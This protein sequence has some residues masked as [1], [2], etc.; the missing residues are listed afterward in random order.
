MASGAHRGRSVAT[1]ESPFRI[2]MGYDSHEDIA[3]RVAS[4]SLMRRASV[5][6]EISPL[7]VRAMRANGTYTR[8]FDPKQ[9]TEFTY[10]RFF[11]PYLTGYKGWAMFVDDDFLWLGDVAELLDAIDDRYAIIVVK[12][13]ST[14]TE[15]T[16][17]AGRGQEPYPR[18]NWSSMIL[19][20]CGHPANAVLTPDLAN[21]ETGQ[22]LH[23]FT[24]ITDDSL[25]AE[26]PYKWNFLV[27]WYK[28]LPDD[29]PP[30]AIH[31][32]EGGP[33]FPDHREANVDYS[34]EWFA[35]L[36]KYEATLP[37]KRQ[38]CPYELFSEQGHKPLAGY[39]N[40]DQR[41]SWA[42]EKKTE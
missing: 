32:T 38:L 2:Y 9:T 39:P 40:S 21:R 36:K 19:Y 1:K 12:N 28:K 11:V 35:E 34:E 14:P 37:E 8:P 15:K 23:R 42:D 24:W 22:F 16:K 29:S 41:W 25:I 13:D 3:F 18:K 30:G 26:V 33:W 7:D 31:Y 20:N 5:P 17:L 4:F 10:L 27:G 6:I